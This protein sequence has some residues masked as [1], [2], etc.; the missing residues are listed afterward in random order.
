MPADH[1][2][3]LYNCF[4]GQFDQ[5]SKERGDCSPQ[6]LASGLGPAPATPSLD[7]LDLGC[8][9]GLCGV[10]FRDWARTLIG[11]DLAANMLAEARK[12][13]TYDELIESDLLAFLQRCP[14]RFDLIVASDVLLFL[15]DLG[16]LF[17]EIQ[18]ALRPG[19]RFAFTIDR[20]EG[21]GDYRLMPWIHFAH[22]LAYVENL[23]ATTRMQMVQAQKVVFPRDGG[24]EA[25]GFVVVLSRP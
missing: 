13:G 5:Y 25:P 20:L 19:G 3:A 21:A 24:H 10:Q 23:A 2:G 4:A 9:T 6:M 8:G 18:Q 11:V 1:V 16:P 12:R 22:S 7:I 17:T 15:G 14:G